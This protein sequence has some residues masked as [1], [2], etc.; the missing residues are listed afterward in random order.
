VSTEIYYFSGTGN[1]LHVAEELQKRIPKSRLIPIMSLV[2]EESVTTHGETVGFVFPHY[3][4]TL[5]KVVHRFIRK[6]ELGSARYLFAVATRGRTKTMAFDEI[7]RI[8]KEKGRRLDSFFVLTMPSGSEPLMKGYASQITK[9]RIDRL[10]SQMLARLDSIQRIIV[11]QK[12]SRETDT[13]AIPPPRFLVPFLPLIEAATPLLVR[14]GKMVETSFEFYYDETCTSCGICEHVCLAEK[15]QM[16]DD[17][18]VWQE[19][20][21][22][23]GCF[24]CLNF[25]PKESIRARSSW[26]LKSHTDQNGRY[27]HP[28]I[29]AKDIAAQKQMMASQ[30]PAVA[31]QGN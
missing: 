20:V 14:L 27:H 31:H 7:D 25:C 29:T 9:E 2:N 6:L 22:C 13:G 15:L 16:V 5:P 18:P 1:S 24:A 17:R 26:Y 30:H 8:L 10:Q 4:S 12:T 28:Q 21:K 23:H 19:A 3:A 11:D